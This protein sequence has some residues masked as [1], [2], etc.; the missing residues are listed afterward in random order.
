MPR[1]TLAKVASLEGDKDRML[2]MPDG[3]TMIVFSLYD[4]NLELLSKGL[5]EAILRSRLEA[6]ATR[7][8]A[9]LA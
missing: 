3:A 2:A 9:H 1:D 8:G 4:R 7:T 5:S 6:A